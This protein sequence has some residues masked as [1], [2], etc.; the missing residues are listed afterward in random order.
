MSEEFYLLI[1]KQ[2]IF[3]VFY[4]MI[5]AHHYFLF[6]YDGVCTLCEYLAGSRHSELPVSLVKLFLKMLGI[7][8]GLL[9]LLIKIS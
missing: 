4:P 7:F 2:I 8:I 3:V 9:F 1:H 6:V 5:E